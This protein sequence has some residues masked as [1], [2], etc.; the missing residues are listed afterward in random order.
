MVVWRTAMALACT[1]GSAACMGQEVLTVV[2]AHLF[3]YHDNGPYENVNPGVY[4]VQRNWTV[5]VYHN[6][7]R[8][9][10]FY[11]GYTWSWHTT[12][13]PLIDSY[14]L[15]AAIANGYPNTIEKTDL[16]AL[17]IP[18]VRVPLTTSMG[19]RV[20]LL[21]YVRRYNP[22]TSLHFCVEHAF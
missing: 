3:T 20:S 19:L 4:L 11:G 9:T 15:T 7:T 10:S 17:L 2:G 6:S 8:K 21:P 22:A 5:G 1:L 16:S 12:R 18:S 13:V 14:A